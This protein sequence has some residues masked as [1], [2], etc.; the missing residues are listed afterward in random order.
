MPYPIPR[1]WNVFCEVSEQR[2][3]LSV[4]TMDIYIESLLIY[5]MN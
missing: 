2:Y 3:S 4:Q 1:A 5:Y